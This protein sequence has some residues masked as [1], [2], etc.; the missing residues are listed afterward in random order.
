MN[1]LPT[2]LAKKVVRLIGKANIG[3]IT[4]G[5]GES[6]LRLDI[7]EILD[8]CINNGIDT[9]IITNGYI[10]DDNMCRLR[11]EHKISEMLISLDGPD[12]ETH[13][14]IRGKQGSFDQV[15]KAIKLFK[16]H[17]IRFMVL[18]NI[19]KLNCVNFHNFFQVIEELNPAVWRINDIK[20]LGIDAATQIELNVEHNKLIATYYKIFDFKKSWSGTISFDSIFA[21][22]SS[23]HGEEHLLNGCHCGRLS[24]ALRANGDIL[25][26][27]YYDKKIGNILE[28]DIAQLWKESATLSLIRNRKPE[29][30]CVQCN[31]ISVCGGGCF[32]RAYMDKGD[33]NYPDPLCWYR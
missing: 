13:D 6:L 26:C 23:N 24:L 21:E 7:W 28:D 30:K 10:V 25:A 33:I 3:M 31:N 12:Y 9:R 19:N 20:N 1:E 2:H 17:K 15:I 16:K 4:F 11:K 8:E 32:A 5:G 14:L 18:T 27:V 22:C 29:G